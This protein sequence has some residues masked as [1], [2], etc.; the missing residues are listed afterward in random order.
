MRRS[1][2]TNGL[3][4]CLILGGY[5]IPNAACQTAADKQQPDAQSDTR[6]S[7]AQNGA[8]AQP[9]TVSDEVIREVLEPLRQGMVTQNLQMVM[10]VFDQKEFSDYSDLEGELRAFFEQ[11]SEVRFRYQILQVAANK[12]R[13]SLTADMEMDTLPYEFTTLPTR[14]SVQMRFQLALEAKGWKVTA[15]TPSDFFNVDF[16]AA[17]A[18]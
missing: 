10:S 6:D 3:F 17:G 12:N 5:L 9:L 13:G 14:R 11:T 2:I 15:F 4:I 1:I 7:K 16:N 18:R 8:D